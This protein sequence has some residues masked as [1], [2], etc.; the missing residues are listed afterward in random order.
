MLKLDVWK[1][2]AP[3]DGKRSIP[4]AERPAEGTF[5]ALPCRPARINIGEAGPMKKKVRLFLLGVV[6]GSFAAF[7][8]GMNLG[9]GVP[10]L[11]NPLAQPGLQA[12]LVD[13]VKSSTETALEGARATIH[14]ATRP[15]PNGA[16]ES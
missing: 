4:S 1:D 6:L 8:I 15:E 9:R 16:G 2:E 10:L 13:G 5:A 12:Q 14:Q 11:S 3:A 7:P